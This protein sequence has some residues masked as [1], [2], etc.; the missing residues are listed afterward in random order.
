MIP[1]SSKWLA[2]VLA[3]SVLAACGGGSSPST[4]ASTSAPTSAALAVQVVPAEASAQVTDQ[5]VDGDRANRRASA[6]TN[7]VYIVQID[8]QPVTAYDGSI[9]GLQATKPRKGQKIDPDSPAVTNY[10]AHLASRHDAVLRGVGAAKKLYSY[11]YVFNGFAAELS[12]SQA[13]QLALSKGVLAVSKDEVRT[14]DTASTATF[15]GLA[16]DNGL[17]AKTGAK[18][19]NVIIGMVDSGIWPES[20]SF[21]DRTGTNGNGTQ[22]GK[23]DYHQIP[24]WHGKCTPGDQFDASNCNQKLIG[25]RY[26]NAGWG[27]NAAINANWPGAEYNSPRDWGG[28]GTHTSSTAAGNSNVTVTGPAAAFGKVTGM[29]PRARIA[30]YKVCWSTEAFQGGCFNSDSVAAIEQAVA[31]GVDVINFS[32]SGTTTNFRDPVEIAFMNAADAGVF[33]AAS[34]GNSGPTTGTVAHPSPWL[35][36]VAAGTH[37]R[38]AVGSALVGNAT[39]T[40]AS[41]AAAS[42]GPAPL[43]DSATA[44][45]PTASATA[46][47][48]CFS[49]SWP[50]G[51]GLDPAKVKG[52]IVLCAR[53]TNDRVDKSKAVAEAGGIGMILVN[54]S[55]N[56]LVADYHSV[57]TVH[58]DVAYRSALQ[59]AAAAG[60]TATVNQSHLDFST[61]APYTASFSSRGPSSASGGVLLKPDVIAPGQSILA[62]VAPPGNS[63]RSFDLYDGTSMSSPHVAG[64]AALFKELNPS[65]SPMAI[66]SALMTTAYDVLDG[67]NTHPLVIFRQGAG[68]VRP[69]AAT[70]PGLVFDSGYADWLGF[71]CGTQ[72][73]T[74]FCTAAGVPV[75]APHNMNVASIAL[76]AMPGIQK[77][78]RRV[79]NVGKTS[80]TYTA[81]VAGLSGFGVT[82]SPASLEIGPNETKSV[83]F[84]F[85][86]TAATLNAYTG[87]QLTLNDGTHNVRV[88][89]V[90]QPVAL[91]APTEVNGTSYKVSFGYD[92][93]FS[94]TARG[95]VPATKSSDTVLTNGYKEFSFTMAPGLSYVRFS[96]FDTD[97]SAPSDLDM[98]VY[99]NG[100]KVASSGGPTA[101]EQVSFTSVPPGAVLTV[102]VIGFATPAAGTTFTLYS[103]QLG[104]TAAGNMTVSAPASAMTGQSG[105][106]TLTT[107]GL[108][109]G[110]KYLG[111][112]VYGGASGLPAPTIVRIDN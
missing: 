15:L 82:M 79:T 26:Y 71:L 4:S 109:T 21:S 86:R 63:G 57:P 23:L 92:G 39:Y 73:P 94:A 42:A 106:V 33:V 81:S 78:T 29:A 70:D 38:S 43:V 24:G 93:N 102:R 83:D 91:G 101:A 1:T 100:A 75:V 8:G 20:E 34:A 58:V 17:W 107:S 62:A 95:L 5:P 55:P 104:T 16:G 72:L 97:V 6:A 12:D 41:L 45:L 64:I 110:D 77:V 7:K 99:Y 68:H 85:T 90:I 103:W 112:I 59:A 111:S 54:T 66:K 44:G 105:T 11:G 19:E 88:P 65:W 40:G 69:L 98:E 18:G 3:A 50:G 13:Q 49:S 60:T 89:V 74:A 32:I 2:S 56:N 25:A 80:A 76:N 53:G 28:H 87:G 96:L 10:M 30:A 108:N 61:P 27:G 36:T 14:M 52:N 9:K 37:N 31:D 47:S 48:L 46:A 35:T 84:T 22:D 67:P 51:P